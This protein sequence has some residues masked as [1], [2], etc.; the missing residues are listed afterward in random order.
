MLPGGPNFFQILDS[1][2]L[3]NS[4]LWARVAGVHL[5]QIQRSQHMIALKIPI[6]LCKINVFYNKSFV[7]VLAISR[8]RARLGNNHIGNLL[9]LEMCSLSTQNDHSNKPHLHWNPENT[10]GH[11][12]TNVF[13]C[14]IIISFET[15]R[16]KSKDG[17]SRLS[18]RC[19]VS[20][21]SQNPE[22]YMLDEIWPGRP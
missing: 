18:R 5:A 9:P 1:F 21:N 10:T 6:C 16:I 15:D 7:P 3:H 22:K 19:H 14:Q 2:V 13:Y 20:A 11:W 4:G 17:S 8:S 12:K